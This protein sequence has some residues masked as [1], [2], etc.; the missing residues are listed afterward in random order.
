L[1]SWQ[2][3]NELFHAA[4]ERPPG[5]R[6]RFVADAAAD[7][8]DVHREVLSLL[9]AHDRA[10]E[11]FLGA[12]A[13]DL[14]VALIDL[15][16]V[17]LE[18]RQVGPYLIKREVGRGGM[19]VVYE[20]EDTRLARPVAI[21]ALAPEFTR[22][23]QRRER[24]RLEARAAATLSH[25]G[26][27]TV[28][29][30]EELD[31]HLYIV[32]E[33]VTGRTLRDLLDAGPVPL[34]TLLH[35]GVQIA[36]ALAAAHAR[37]VTHRDLKPENVICGDDGAAKILDF[38]V[39]RIVSPAFDAA[40]PRLTDPG[41]I[42]G[43]PAYMSPEQIDGRTADFR[44]D[45]FSLG[46]V[47]YEMA[48][49]RHPFEASTAA[50]TTARIL[51]VEA[52]PLPDV[53]QLLPAELDRIVQKCLRKQPEERYQSAAD[54]A[55]DLEHLQKGTTGATVVPGAPRRLGTHAA[56]FSTRWWWRVHQI[57]VMLV[58][59]GMVYPVW[60]ASEWTGSQ[61]MI[62]V[63]Y[64][65]LLTAAI[66]GVL[67]THLLFTERFNATALAGQLRDVVPWVRRS[68]AIY[69]LMLFVAAVPIARDHKAVTTLMASVAV[70]AAVT[71]LIVE[72]Q[73]TRAAFTK[74]TSGLRKRAPSR[75]KRTT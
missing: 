31:G 70:G 25:P 5:E 40:A 32:S 64:V 69:G 48:A 60:R 18:G 20:A 72:P 74:R 23:E 61:W 3:V 55:V 17:H 38:G 68:D 36:R 1:E 46:V 29:A 59:A 62:A 53:N 30:L 47:L 51:A 27:A 67:R 37:G 45:L 26:I 21:K 7:D 39:A 14:A 50:S 9:A 33:F 54:L 52:P 15:Q 35:I 44:S 10:G 16:P 58:Y 41:T 49:G 34:D 8:A 4:L 66:N 24:L 75:Q 63:F 43:T 19:G 65:A 57:G 73:T 11:K 6:A 42:V 56:P 28:F 71:F 13:V 22:D 12:P 2:R